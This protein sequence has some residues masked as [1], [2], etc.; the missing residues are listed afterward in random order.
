MLSLLNLNTRSRIISALQKKKV[1]E[2]E[3]EKKEE[4]GKKKGKKEEE[5]RRGRITTYRLILP[6]LS[7]IKQARYIYN[8]PLNPNKIGVN[9]YVQI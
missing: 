2:K 6:N 7:N 9:T 1:E 4:K 8:C 5:E 3:E